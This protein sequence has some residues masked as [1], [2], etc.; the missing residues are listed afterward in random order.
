MQRV[1]VALQLGGPAARLLGALPQHVPRFL[2]VGVGVV[3][4]AAGGAPVAPGPTRLLAPNK[5]H[6]SISV[7]TR[8]IGLQVETPLSPQPLVFIVSEH[9]LIA[10]RGQGLRRF[11]YETPRVTAV[12]CWA[13]VS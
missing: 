7:G 2:R 6:P 12:I 8:V 11:Q 3:H 10:A 9:A 4:D 1:D 13:L 5:P